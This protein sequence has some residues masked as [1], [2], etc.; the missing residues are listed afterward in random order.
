MYCKSLLV[1]EMDMMTALCSLA[2][3]N[4]TQHKVHREKAWLNKLF[5]A[6]KLLSA[7]TFSCILFG[8]LVVDQ[9]STVNEK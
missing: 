2:V 1:F 7:T 4:K 6:S 3:P 9:H 8:E 5:G